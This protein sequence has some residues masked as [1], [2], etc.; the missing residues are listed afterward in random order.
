MKRIT[1]ITGAPNTSYNVKR[2]NI[3]TMN[4]ACFCSVLLNYLFH[5]CLPILQEKETFQIISSTSARM[6]KTRKAFK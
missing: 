1:M 4:V 6:S 3:S 5:F 2:C